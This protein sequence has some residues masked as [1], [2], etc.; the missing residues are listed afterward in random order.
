MT[1]LSRTSLYRALIVLA[2]FAALLLAGCQETG[3]MVD[4]P[5][6][7]PYEASPL[8]ADGRSAR[9]LQPGTV[10]YAAEGSLNANDPALTGLDETGQPAQGFPASVT[11]D[12]KL[13]AK[14]QERFD[15]Y[16]IP[17][18]GPAGEGNGKVTGFGF[19]K[20]PSLLADQAKAL[21]NGDIFQI[22]TNGRGKMWPYGYRVKADERWAVIAYVRALQ[23]K[24]GAIKASDLTP[25]DLQ[26]IGGAK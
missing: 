4:Q 11:V 1:H 5:R 14:G 24:N 2:A 13:L 7:D 16:C 15:I 26:Q 17:C 9:P 22:I 12:D 3:T 6:Y 8:F 18:H 10:A 19:G 25:A 20:P 23:L 21:T